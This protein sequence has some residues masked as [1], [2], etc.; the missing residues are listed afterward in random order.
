MGLF[1]RF[2]KRA[3]PET[4]GTL[5]AAMVRTALKYAP[6]G[7]D[8]FQ[9]G[10]ARVTVDQEEVIRS[11]VN[12]ATWIVL[13][14]LLSEMSSENLHLTMELGGAR[15]YIDH[16]L[17]FLML[18]PILVELKNEGL[19]PDGERIAAMN[20]I[21]PDVLGKGEEEAATMLKA[22]QLADALVRRSYDSTDKENDVVATVLEALWG[23][24]RAFV[25]QNGDAKVLQSMVKLYDLYVRGIYAPLAAARASGSTGE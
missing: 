16:S 20:L 2:R 22:K 13:S 8:P 18:Y 11:D 6:P 24:A 3:K 7:P 1:D 12:V 25:W 10:A 23:G 19:E 21:G 15:E 9:P 14:H 5:H 17:F 4:P